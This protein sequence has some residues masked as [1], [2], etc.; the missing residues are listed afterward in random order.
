MIEDFLYAIGRLERDSAN[1]C[2]RYWFLI[3][4]DQFEVHAA[5]R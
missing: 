4:L 5:Q 3:G 1:G 2:L